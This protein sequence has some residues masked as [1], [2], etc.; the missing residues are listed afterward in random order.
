MADKNSGVHID[1]MQNHS[2]AGKVKVNS[3]WL[4][5]SSVSSEWKK[6]FDQM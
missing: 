6:M 2:I 4:I 5:V 3:A 1:L